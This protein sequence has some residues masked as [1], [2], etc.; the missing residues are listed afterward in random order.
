M[1]F[2][3]QERGYNVNVKLYLRLDST[4]I[5]KWVLL[6]QAKPIITGASESFLVS[7]MI[8]TLMSILQCT[9]SLIMLNIRKPCCYEQ[10]VS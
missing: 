6:V 9:F 10:L 4:C 8:I 5:I 3:Y 7:E 1:K 2:K